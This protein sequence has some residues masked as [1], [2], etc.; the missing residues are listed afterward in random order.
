MKPTPIFLCFIT[1]LLAA[2][3]LVDNDLTCSLCCVWSNSL[4]LILRS[5]HCACSRH[6]TCKVDSVEFTLGCAKSASDTAVLINGC[7][8][9]SK[10]SVCL[11]L[12]LLLSKSK[13][14]IIKGILG[15]SGLLA[16][17]LSLCVVKALNLNVVFI[18]LDELSSVTGKVKTVSF[19]NETVDGYVTFSSACNSINGKSCSCKDIASY[20]DI[21]LCSL[22]CKRIS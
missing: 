20:E 6:I 5:V 19:M 4:E 17:N 22:S 13:S 14:K 18:K 1:R 3:K 15:D 9:A 11:S 7:S 12:N 16:R 2:C 8:T 10:T 21:R